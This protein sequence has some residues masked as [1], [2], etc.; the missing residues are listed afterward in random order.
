MD[1]GEIGQSSIA[2]VWLAIFTSFEPVPV[3]SLGG[4]IGIRRAST[5]VGVTSRDVRD[6]RG[7]IGTDALEYEK[8]QA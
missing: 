2:H 4:K 3:S 6:G 8:P 5:V 7:G 1:H